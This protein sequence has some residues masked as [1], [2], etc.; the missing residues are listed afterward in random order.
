MPLPS[1]IFYANFIRLCFNFFKLFIPFVSYCSFAADSL[2]RNMLTYEL[3]DRLLR[4][5]HSSTTMLFNM[6]VAL[7]SENI[8]LSG[9]PFDASDGNYLC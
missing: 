8:V 7:P 4:V 2:K 5:C 6:Q 9:F 1:D 3:A